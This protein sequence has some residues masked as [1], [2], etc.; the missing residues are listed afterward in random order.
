MSYFN[1]K[2]SPYKVKDL[3]PVN[4]KIQFDLISNL[5]LNLPMAKLQVLSSSK[6]FQGDK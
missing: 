3:V 6:Q 1:S 2:Y 5:E 4:S